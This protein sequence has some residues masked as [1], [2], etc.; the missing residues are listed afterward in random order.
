M[1]VAKEFSRLI[2]SSSMV[3]SK[4]RLSVFDYFFKE[5]IMKVN[6]RIVKWSYLELGKKF[7]FTINLLKL[8][9]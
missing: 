7:Y 5:V 2:P 4:I 3:S 9:V 8:L 1:V 6:N